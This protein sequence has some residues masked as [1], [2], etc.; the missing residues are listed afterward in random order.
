MP[1]GDPVS[2][3][4]WTCKSARRLAAE[5]GQLGHRVSRTVVG[6]LLR[7]QK[8]SLQGNLLP[9][10]S[11]AITRCLASGYRTRPISCH[12]RRIVCTAKAAVSL[13]IPTLTQPAFAAIS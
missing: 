13:S 7:Q 2:P 4:R 11:A 3:L 10:P 8:F 6:E 12:Q 1:G 5:L 9:P